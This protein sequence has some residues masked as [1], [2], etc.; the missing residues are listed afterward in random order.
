MAMQEYDN[1]NVDK[2]NDEGGFDIRVILDYLRA[3]WKLFVLSVVVCCAFAF[4]YLRYATPVYNVTA[5]K[6]QLHQVTQCME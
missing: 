4:V 5:T 1:I 2:E 6:E 3:Y